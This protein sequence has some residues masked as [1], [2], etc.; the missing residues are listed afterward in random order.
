MLVKDRIKY[1]QVK[2]VSRFFHRFL[3]FLFYF[4]TRIGKKIKY[5]YHFDKKRYRH[6]QVMIV[7]DHASKMLCKIVYAGCSF[8]P[9]NVVVSTLRITTRRSIFNSAMRSGAILVNQGNLSIRPMYEM[10]KVIAEGGNILIMPEGRF[11]YSGSN[12]PVKKAF[13]GFIKKSRVDVV[14]C[15][16]FGSYLKDPY[17]ANTKREGPHEYHYSILFKAEELA[18]LTEE[19]IY[20]KLMSSFRYNDFMYNKTA[21]NKY[22]SK[23][24]LAEGIENILYSCPNCGS[25]FTIKGEKNDIVCKKCGTRVSL[26][27]YYDLLSKDER[28]PYKNID[29]WYQHQCNDVNNFVDEKT[30]ISYMAKLEEYDIEKLSFDAYFIT[31]EGK[32]T[33]DYSGIK[34][35]GTRNNQPF[36]LFV[37]IDKVVTFYADKENNK[38][39]VG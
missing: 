36:T 21:R 10:S 32:V 37:P 15:K 34:Y 8:A 16:S 1:H 38:Q 14:I 3:M 30:T 7:S 26:N 9:V 28:F 5:V 4:T 6:R 29:E 11:S 2:P 19:E 25:E 33:I 24:G 18:Q 13:A 31:G 20:A 35:V 23:T 27:E 12:L 39:Y 22:F 17:F